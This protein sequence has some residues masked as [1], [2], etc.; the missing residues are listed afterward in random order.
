MGHT[1][2]HP[3]YLKSEAEIAVMR[4]A[5]QLLQGIVLEVAA[6]ARPGV[7][8][9]ELDKLAKSRIKEAGAR[10]AFLNLYGFPATL[11][12]SINEQVVHGIP[13]AR[14]L[15]EGDIASIDCGLVLEGFFA[16]TAYT[17]GVG[18]VGEGAANLMR[19]T[20]E[21][22]YKG[23][24]QSVAGNR[25]GDIGRA[26]EQHVKAHGYHVTEDYTGHGVGRHLH[27]DPK[28]YNDGKRRGERLRPGMVFAIEPM[29][30]IGTSKT[31]ELKDGWTVV[32]AD[33]SLSAH[34]EHTVAVTENGPE[35]LTLA[36][37]EELPEELLAVLAAVPGRG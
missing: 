7:T 34:F 14:R 23:I 30:N 29:I 1:E 35:V 13:S 6:A 10:P 33:G 12:L 24:A 32:T 22:L 27:E 28:I 17:V 3:L 9:L 21:S 15:E 37:G 16:D 4:R 26:V 19:A 18:R 5:G 25:T 11:C 20:R 2:S 31:R 36:D 8:G